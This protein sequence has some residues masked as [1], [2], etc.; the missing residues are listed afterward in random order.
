MCKRYKK[1]G[2]KT[3]AEIVSYV[4]E[5]MFEPHLV[6]WYQADQ[7]QIDALSLDDYLSKLAQL[8]LKKNWLYDILETILSSSQGHQNFMDWKIELE[9]LN[10]ILATSTPTKALTKAELK[11]QLPP[12]PENQHQSGTCSGHR[13]RPLGY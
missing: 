8:V 6:A 4:A 3:D 12:R 11:T 5:G 1:H 7:T 2:E 9:N 10:T 13:S